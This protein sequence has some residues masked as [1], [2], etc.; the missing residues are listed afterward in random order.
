[1]RVL[2]RIRTAL[3]RTCNKNNR[4]VLPNGRCMVCGEFPAFPPPQ[5]FCPEC[6]DWRAV[7]GGACHLAHL[8]LDN[9]SS[10]R[11]RQTPGGEPCSECRALADPDVVLWD[12]VDRSRDEREDEA[13]ERD[14][15]DRTW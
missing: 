11:L 9:C 7:V 10:C 1:M 2:P 8:H 12:E 3:C 6:G 15:D 4:V 14:E 5:K 13:S